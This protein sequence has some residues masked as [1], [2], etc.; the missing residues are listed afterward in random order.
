MIKKILGFH[1]ITAIAGDAQRNVDFYSGVLGLR[2]VKLTV[3][4]DDPETY[5]LYYGDER[6]SPGSIL[7]FFSWPG[8]P[9]GRRGTGQLTTIAF[10]VPE[11]SLGYW[12]ER[13]D[14][15][16]V[17]HEAPVTRLDE[18]S[19]TLFDP[20]GLR[21]ELVAGVAA[22]PESPWKEGPVSPE[23]AIRRLRGVTLTEEGYELTA[24]L[25][26]Q[27]LGF[28][29]VDEVGSRF[30]FQT[31]TGEPETVVDVLCL[32]GLQSGW[33]SVGAAHHVAWRTPN[34][35]QQKSWREEIFGLGANVT[36]VMDRRYFRS[37]YFREPGGVLFEIATDPPGFTV[38]EPVER[39]GSKLMLPPWLEPDRARIEEVLPRLR[40]PQAAYV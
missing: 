38:D 37:I 6:G 8:A 12:L 4:Y 16:A 20:D 19:L 2:L 13:L 24:S 17:T 5:H 28:R 25:L 26:T 1:H 34:A 39:L 27:T 22:A 32:P 10:S 33:I 7:T 14:D 35:D 3:N 29:L 21:L 36:P 18:E 9:G 31:G 11:G 15:N 30:R 23:R 40:L